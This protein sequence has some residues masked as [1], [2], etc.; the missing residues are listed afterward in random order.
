MERYSL[1]DEGIIDIIKKH[2]PAT[3]KEAVKIIKKEKG[4]QYSIQ[5]L[6]KRFKK[7]KIK[8]KTGRPS[9]VKKKWS[10]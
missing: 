7:L 2:Q 10:Y 8:L 3:L 6:H 9:H 5:G 1:S 4:V